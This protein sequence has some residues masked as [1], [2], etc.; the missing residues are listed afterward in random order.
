[1]AYTFITPQ[2]QF[3]AEFIKIKKGE[4]I[5]PCTLKPKNYYLN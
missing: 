2:K 3:N 5:L 1:M 4:K